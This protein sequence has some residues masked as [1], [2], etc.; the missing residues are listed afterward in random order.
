[1]ESLS[2]PT[3]EIVRSLQ[4]LN[5]GRPFELRCLHAKGQRGIL[6]GVYNDVEKAATDVTEV[7]QV[8]Y[9]VYLTLNELGADVFTDTPLNALRP[10]TETTREGDIARRL[11]LLID[12]DVKRPD[13][14]TCSTDCEKAAAR[15]TTIAVRTYLADHGWRQ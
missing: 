3:P 11:W 5:Q 9:N 10:A 4:L 7:N 12:V 8:G 14:D 2:P 6:S 13:K 1:M 15:Q